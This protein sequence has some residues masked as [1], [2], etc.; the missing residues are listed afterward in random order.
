[1]GVF[2]LPVF[3]HCSQFHHFPRLVVDTISEA[4]AAAWHPS[5]APPKEFWG[6]RHPQVGGAASVVQLSLSPLPE[7]QWIESKSWGAGFSFCGISLK[8]KIA[9]TCSLSTQPLQQLSELRHVLRCKPIDL[10][11]YR[12]LIL[13]WLQA[14]QFPS[15]PRLSSLRHKSMWCNCHGLLSHRLQTKCF[16]CGHSHPGRQ[17]PPLGY[18]QLESMA[19]KVFVSEHFYS[20][21]DTLTVRRRDGTNL[22]CVF[23][24]GL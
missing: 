1:M 16:H 4:S 7:P 3:V 22:A 23:T 21:F 24:C 14:A 8:K 20:V 18:N 9:L 12:D 19:L 11:S 13:E 6:P 5:S 2:Y 15:S 17:F 10:C